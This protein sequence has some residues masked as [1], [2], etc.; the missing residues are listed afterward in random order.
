MARSKAV[1]RREGHP[2][3]AELQQGPEPERTVPQYM[4]FSCT[5]GRQKENKKIL[6][7]AKMVGLV[8]TMR[9]IAL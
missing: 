8:S 3:K 6:I 9:I 1:Q 7:R 5:L 4:D 2:S